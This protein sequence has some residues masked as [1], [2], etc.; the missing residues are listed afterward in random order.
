MRNQM[1]LRWGVLFSFGLLTSCEIFDTAET[2]L[3]SACQAELK[4]RLI[5]PSTY[6]LLEKTFV[7]KELTFEEWT[8]IDPPKA[9]ERKARKQL[10][11]EGLKAKDYTV[12]MRYD[13]ANAFGTPIAKTSV[14]S[15]I[16]T[17]DLAD[18]KTGTKAY[19]ALRI[20]GKTRDEIDLAELESITGLKKN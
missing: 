3:L 5:A 1:A 8:E 19:F 12:V 20:D 17:D 16:S 13:S 7:V 14:C 9:A 6:N 2:T 11:K 4:S 18:L 15:F 10:Y